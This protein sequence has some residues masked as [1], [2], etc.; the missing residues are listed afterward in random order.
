MLMFVGIDWASTE[1]AVCVLDQAGRTIRAF[2]IPHSAAGFNDLVARLRR[3]DAPA[4]LPVAIERPDGRLVDRLLEAGHPV[5]PVRSNA[6]KAWREGEVV[7]GAKSD[8]DD[9]A[10]IAEYL[11]LRRHRLRTLTPFSDATRALRAAV[12]ARGELVRQRVAAINQLTATLDAFWPGAKAVFPDVEREIALSF[13][14]RYPTPESAAGLGE[15]RMAAFLTRH[16]YCGRT[17]A[18]ELLARLHAA[19]AGLAGGAEVTARRDAVLAFVGVLRALNQAIRDLDRSVIA[20]LGEH[21]DSKVFASLPRSGQINAAQLLACWGDCRDA[22]DGPEAV[23]ALAGIVPVT[24]QSGKHASVSFRWACNKRFRNAMTTFAHNSRL[25]S[26]WAAK[27]YADAI[28]RGHDHPHATRVLARAWVRVIWRC[29]VD[30]MPYD[31][32]KHTAAQR[33]AEEEATA[34]RA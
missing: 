24:K 8:T 2:R 6:I 15:R 34:A 11:R 21:P 23:A 4:E 17:P 22:Y 28:A 16:R 29:W 30:Q 1:H 7:S 14:E 33:L 10:V 26:P 5:V 31:P 9:A 20:R 32:V 12:R 18:A 19:P 3:L 25:A 13:L 27:V